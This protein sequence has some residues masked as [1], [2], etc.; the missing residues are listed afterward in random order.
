ML[1]KSGAYLDRFSKFY[2]PSGFIW[3]P[4]SSEFEKVL[5]DRDFSVLLKNFMPNV[6]LTFHY[7]N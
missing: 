6:G 1:L 5:P 7:E 3:E 4:S 2:L